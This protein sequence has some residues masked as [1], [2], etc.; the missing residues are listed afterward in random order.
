MGRREAGRQTCGNGV[1]WILGSKKKKDWE[2]GLEEYFDWFQ[3]PESRRVQFAQMKLAGQARI[4]WRNL[5]ATAERRREPLVST[6]EEMKSRMHGKFVPACY[7]SMIIDEWQHLRQGDNSVVDYIARFDDLMIR[8]N[9]D[10]EPVATL[11]RFRAGLRPE[12]QRELVLQE[13]T[14]LEKAYRLTTHMELYSSHAQ[15]TPTSWF[16]TPDT[17]RFLTPFPAI[18]S[19]NPQPPPNAPTAT[20]PPLP[21]PP[22]RL[23]LPPPVLPT[24][25]HASPTPGGYGN[26]PGSSATPQPNRTVAAAN[27]SPERTTEGRN[28]GGI[29]P[30][31]PPAQSP[32][33]SSR[34]ACFKCQG[35]GHFAS[36]CPSQRQATRLARALLVEIHD[37]EHPPPPEVTKPEID[38]Y[39]ADPDLAAGFEGSPG[40]M[41]CIIKETCP[42]TP[43]ECT[44][45]FARPL[46][47]TSEDPL[48]TSPQ[49]QGAEDP[50]R[51]AIFSTFTKIANSFIKILVDNGSVVNAVV[52]ASIPALGLRP[53]RHPT[54]YKGM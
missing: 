46:N 10:E 54:P 32:T 2:V 23:L 17:V 12:Y 43:L 4:F 6:W 25:T 41:G 35:W 24:V 36:Q 38:I 26:C 33:T 13:I 45:A 40:F 52:A 16:T 42:L 37:E 14:T 3:L 27:I 49:V 50:L 8:C 31:L 18:N 21:H 48:P 34:V 5:Q 47:T 39:E 30:R 11:A 22:L 29:R 28:Q 15:R 44:I 51:T 19:L 1:R 9:I 7:R 20:I 53:E